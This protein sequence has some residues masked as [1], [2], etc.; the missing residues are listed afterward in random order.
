MEIT[1]L[2]TCAQGLVELVVEDRRSGSRGLFIGQDVLLQSLTTMKIEIVSH[3]Q[4]KSAL[5]KS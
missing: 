1:L 3:G 4:G 5:N 2:D